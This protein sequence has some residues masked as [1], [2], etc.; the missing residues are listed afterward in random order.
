MRPIDI[1][2]VSFPYI[3]NRRYKLI[4]LYCA[5]ARITEDQHLH[6][7]PEHEQCRGDND[8]VLTFS[9]IMVNICTIFFK[10]CI[11]HTQR[12]C[13]FRRFS[14]YTAFVFPNNI[15]RF[16]LVAET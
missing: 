1:S 14:Q 6:P 2:T 16:V 11:V 4:L 12:V 8:E 9:S 13:V 7:Q 3:M 10:L 15:N 5:G